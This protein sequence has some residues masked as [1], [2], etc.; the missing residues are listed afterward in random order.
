MCDRRYYAPA[1]APT[2]F[3]VENHITRIYEG[4][5]SP[6]VFI[7]NMTSQDFLRGGG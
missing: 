6:Y 4:F 1:T 3:A 2:T 7:T 5:K